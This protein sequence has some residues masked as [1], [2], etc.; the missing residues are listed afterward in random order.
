MWKQHSEL[1]AALSRLSDDTFNTI[2]CDLSGN[3]LT[4]DLN[5][6]AIKNEHLNLANNN[7]GDDG[8]TA[9]ATNMSNLKSLNLLGNNIGDAGAT[10]TFAQSNS[11]RLPHRN[12][13]FGVTTSEMRVPRPL[14]NL[15]RN[16]AEQINA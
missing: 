7:I 14:L 12:K 1:V 8:A 2:Q 11:K 3:K 13:S 4:D 15:R 9:I 10:A 6:I 16:I 5:N